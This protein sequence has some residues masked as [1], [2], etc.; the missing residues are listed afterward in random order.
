[1][2]PETAF[3]NESQIVNLLLDTHI[4]LWWLA[5]DARLP[6]RARR[7][8]AEEAR[9]VFVS[10][11]SLWEVA[12]KIGKGKLRADLKAIHAQAESSDFT[13]LPIEPAHVLTL[14]R[15]PGHHADPF[16]RMLIAQAMFER[17][18]LLTCDTALQPYGEM[19]ILA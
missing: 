13:H 4:L 9:T 12:V 16:D 2:D 6:A 19:V 18:S 11:V 17:L 10:V 3:P 7:Q 5:D 8:I 1:M 14:S 15:L